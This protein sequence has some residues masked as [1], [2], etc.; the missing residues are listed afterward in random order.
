M[1]LRLVFAL[2]AT[3]L[4]FPAVVRT[5]YKVPLYLSKVSQQLDKRLGYSVTS[6]KMA[7]P[8]SYD[9]VKAHLQHVLDDPSTPSTS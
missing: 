3:P 9:E 2:F 7:V 4:S 5:I 6:D 8:S 1:E